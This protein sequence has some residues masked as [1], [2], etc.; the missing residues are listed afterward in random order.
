MK[1]QEFN[2]ICNLNIYNNLSANSRHLYLYLDK[3]HCCFNYS[4]WFY[5]SQKNLCKYLKISRTTLYKS[6]LELIF[7]GFINQ[8]HCYNY[9]GQRKANE[10]HINNVLEILEE[11]KKDKNNEKDINKINYYVHS[12]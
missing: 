11:I 7:Y 6:V 2:F 3:L 10:Y 1:L 8:R 9:K 5:I 12:V 4:E